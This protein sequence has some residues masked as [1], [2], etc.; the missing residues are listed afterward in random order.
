MT[1]TTILYAGC[2]AL[3]LALTALIVVLSLIHI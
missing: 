2:A 1:V 3:Y